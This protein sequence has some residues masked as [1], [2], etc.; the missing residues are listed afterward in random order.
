M[1]LICLKASSGLSLPLSPGDRLEVS[2]PNEKYFTGVY[3]VN[4]DGNLEIPYLGLLAVGG[5]EPIE[6]QQKLSQALIEQQYF[7]PG[8][9]KLSIEILR[10]AP[11]TVTVKGE[12]FNPGRVL[13]NENNQTEQ[14]NTFTSESRQ[15]TGSNPL[16]RYLTDAIRATGGV[17][18]SADLRHIRIIRAEQEIVADL[19]GE[20]SG[21]PVKD[22][23]LVADDQ[24]I[25]PD[26]GQFQAEL[27][28]PSQI[29]PPGIKVFVSNL[30][31]P[32]TSNAT[33]AIGN[34][35]EGITFP[36]GAR[37]SHAVISANCAGG[38]KPTNADRKAI[39][40]RVNRISGETTVIER[41]VEDLLRESQNDQDN[42]F[43]MPRDGV[44]CYD[45]EITNTRD[46]F[47]TIA[48]FL[49]PLNPLL[50]LRNL[51]R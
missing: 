44:A 9:L 18:P 36:Y 3:E 26:L 1:T 12:V 5:L 20:F 31:V 43:L 4:Q 47:R 10:W 40:V 6:V 13:I 32:A 28:R 8:K 30:S 15:I 39:L 11:I 24:I 21:E 29:T 23:P 33:S 35:E 37:F 22:I 27:V 17:L 42:P 7:P 45:S 25:V 49:S 19:S 46:V 14:N 38:T 34:R 2:I 51:F 16:N 50:L 48:D 41:K